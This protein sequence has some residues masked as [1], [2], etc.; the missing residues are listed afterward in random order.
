[1]LYALMAW[2]KPGALD[3][4]LANRPA[5]LAYLTDTGVVRQ[6][7]P[8]L[9]P[10]EKPCGS[11][12]ILEVPDMAAA[13]TWADADPYAQAGLFDTVQIRPWNRVIDA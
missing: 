4:R 11:L 1:M 3:L 5:H 12:I 10:D 7:G 6:A 2:D 8:L 13:Q 9:G